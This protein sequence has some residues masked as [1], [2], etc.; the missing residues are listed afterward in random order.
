M[1]VARADPHVLK[2]APVGSRALDYSQPFAGTGG[3]DAGSTAAA[4]NHKVDAPSQLHHAQSID[5]PIRALVSEAFFESFGEVVAD[6]STGQFARGFYEETEQGIAS[7]ELAGEGWGNV[8]T[9]GTSRN[10]K[11][12]QVR[13][14][15][16]YD[17]SIIDGQLV[18][19]ELPG[20]AAIVAVRLSSWSSCASG[21]PPQEAKNFIRRLV[22]VAALGRYE[23]IHIILCADVDSSPSLLSG[24]CLLQS[25][26]SI[27]G[28]KTTYHHVTKKDDCAGYRQS[29]VGSS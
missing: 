19:I 24:I 22:N 14:V 27:D 1:D 16:L 15:L 8:H 3:N 21:V 12:D 11:W 13:S 5:Q 2:G 28:V 17:S 4:P 29:D 26:M 6:L 10:R 23:T 18:D 7:M 25:A 20:K 9:L